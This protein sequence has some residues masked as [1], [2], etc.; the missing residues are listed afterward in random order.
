MFRLERDGQG[1]GSVKEKL[2]R[3]MAIFNILEHLELETFLG[4][5]M[6]WSQGKNVFLEE[7]CMILNYGLVVFAVD[8]TYL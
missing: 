7:D 4:D 3:K 5:I 2:R 6:K 8:Q 1:K